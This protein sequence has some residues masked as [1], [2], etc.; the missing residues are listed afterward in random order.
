[1]DEATIWINIDEL[2]YWDRNPNEGD[3]GKIMM[4]IKEF[5]YNDTCQYWNGVIKG[6]NHSVMAL[7]QLRGLGWH[8]DKCKISSKCLAINGDGWQIAMIDTSEMSKTVSNAFGIALNGTQRAG[9]DDPAALAAL[10][11][12]FKTSAEVVLEATSYDLNDLDLLL[13]DIDYS[14]LDEDDSQKSNGSLLAITDVT[15][16]DPHT[17]VKHGDVWKIGSHY[18]IC[19]DVVTE[20]EL[21][22]PYVKEDCWFLP[23]PGVYSIMTEKAQQ[24]NFVMVQPST[25][26]AGHI[27]DKFIEVHGN[28]DISKCN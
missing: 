18:L 22:M 1:V 14:S 11:Q 7:Q 2:E 19:A 12:E 25:Y 13:A 20:Y 23:Y 17:V 8:P 5:G 26:I 9:R 4:S 6:G 24:I 21:W 3:I 28:D 15:I 10:L 16:D 27:I